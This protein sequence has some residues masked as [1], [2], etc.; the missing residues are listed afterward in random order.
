MATIRRALQN[1]ASGPPSFPKRKPAQA[2]ADTDSASETAAAR[3]AASAVSFPKPYPAHLIVH[4]FLIFASFILL[5][6]SITFRPLLEQLRNLDK[7]QHPFLNS[8]TVLPE[9]TAGWVALG[10]ALLVA[11]WAGSMREWLR[12]GKMGLGVSE[13]LRDGNKGTVCFPPCQSMYD[14]L[15]RYCLLLSGR[16]ECCRFHLLRRRLL[17]IYHNS[18]WRTHFNASAAH[19]LACARSRYTHRACPRLRSWPAFVPDRSSFRVPEARS[20]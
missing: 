1:L 15:A 6:R 9:A 8:F 13:R 3:T 14:D 12:E 7:P 11:W 4:V 19:V 16:M 2:P 18:I 10:N 20:A 17:C 5:P